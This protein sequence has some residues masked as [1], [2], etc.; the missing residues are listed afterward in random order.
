ML[1][2]HNLIK[3]CLNKSSLFLNQI[4]TAKYARKPVGAPRAKSK[5]FYVREYIEKDK[6]EQEFIK[7]LING[8][9]AQMRSLYL[10]FQTE[11]KFTSE[12]SQVGRLE[13]EALKKRELA[14]L[15]KN[16]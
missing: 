4:R 10:L 7:P 5:R 12:S 15:E 6:E 3:T 16:E 11:K 8:Y 13:I 2:N 14:L 1:L 9:K